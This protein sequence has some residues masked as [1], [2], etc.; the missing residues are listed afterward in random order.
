MLCPEAKR[1][2]QEL[3]YIEQAIA[4]AGPVLIEYKVDE[5]VK[6]AGATHKSVFWGSRW[7]PL[8]NKKVDRKITRFEAEDG[9][10]AEVWESGEVTK[11]IE[12]RHPA[13]NVWS[14]RNVVG[15]D[16]DTTLLLERHDD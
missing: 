4:L 9:W 13:D 2:L 3:S 6:E 7:Y 11:Y 15:V 1:W 8:N 14:I 5:I 10:N 12:I 16:E